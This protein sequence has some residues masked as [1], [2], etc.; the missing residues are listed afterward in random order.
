MNPER[1]VHPR[2]QAPGRAELPLQHDRLLHPESLQGAPSSSLHPLLLSTQA[3]TTG[4]LGV[5][6]LGRH[7]RAPALTEPRRRVKLSRAGRE[8]LEPP[9]L[10]RLS[11]VRGS[12][13]VAINTPVRGRG[14]PRRERS[15]PQPPSLARSPAP[16]FL[17]NLI[18]QFSV[19]P[20]GPGRS[21]RREEAAPALH[22][23]ESL[24]A[25]LERPG[26]HQGTG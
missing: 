25:A 24:Q 14:Q 20:S 5:P 3:L 23:G 9:R 12:G 17:V 6:G 16:S 1:W 7:C 13:N 4:D 18:D 22:S 11:S 19:P 21:P 26:L 15:A 2:S 10:G 8:E